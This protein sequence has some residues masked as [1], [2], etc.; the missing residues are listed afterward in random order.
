MKVGQMKDHIFE[1]IGYLSKS[2]DHFKIP[3]CKNI[4][5]N[6]GYYTMHNGCM[7]NSG[8]GWGGACPILPPC[9]CWN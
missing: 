9:G 1:N 5:L 2:E 8:V 7:S 4:M 6:P 3:H